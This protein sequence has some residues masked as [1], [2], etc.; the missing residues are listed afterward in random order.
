MKS[1]SGL[2]I[3]R[4]AILLVGAILF[5]VIALALGLYLIIAGLHPES[6]SAG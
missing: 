5:V 1:G 3:R 4:G 2:A 6:G